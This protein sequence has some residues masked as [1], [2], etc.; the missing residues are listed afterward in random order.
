MSFESAS[1]QDMAIVVEGVAKRFDIFEHPRDQLKQ[2][3][4]P[5]LRRWFG[6]APKQYFREF[7]AL[8]D[9]FMD[10]RKGE[11]CGIVGLNGSGKSTLLQII[12]GT[13]EPTVGKVTVHGRIAALLE[14]G[15]GFN[16]EFTGR[17]NVYMNG[18]LLGFSR[19]QVDAKF[20][21]IEAFADIGEHFDQPMLTYS[22]GMQM[23]VAFAVATAFDPD[24]LIID[25]AL[26]V[27]DAYFQQKCFHR[28]ERFKEAGGTLLF[29]SHDANT[30]KQLCDKVVLLSHGALLAQGVPKT[31]IDLYEGLVA[32][33]TDMSEQE[34]S[35]SQGDAVYIPHANDAEDDEELVDASATWT[36]A[37]TITTNQDAALVDFRM[38]DESGRRVVHLESE[39]PLTIAYRIRLNKD[40]E[41]PAFGLIV[42]DRTGRSVFETSTYAM[43]LPDQPMAKGSHALVRFQFDFNLRAGQY[44][45]S[46]GVADKG[47]SK[48]EF[49]EYSLLMHDVD[50]I[51]LYDATDAIYYGGVF[52]MKPTVSINV[53]EQS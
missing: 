12:T 28:I 49:E 35:V 7:W 1:V 8:R 40:F 21:G 23:R 48:S 42:R 6:F 29:V 18:A 10:V 26:A 31:I 25:E 20:A 22:S 33:K 41:R 51:Q 39:K 13:L 38:L 30:V 43:R 14:L 36:K 45:F 53:L 37:T 47:F 52:N 9:V 27:G 24:I 46:V 5:R 15:S 4:L 50:Q 44:S 2:F 34:V 16:P 3:F 17:E 11:S 19:A 32:K